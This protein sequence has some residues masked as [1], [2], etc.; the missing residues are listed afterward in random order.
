MYMKYTCAI[1]QM[2]QG[3]TAVPD[4]IT[5]HTINDVIKDLVSEVDDGTLATLVSEQTQGSQAQD[6]TD[7]H[8]EVGYIY[9]NKIY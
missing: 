1:V 5:S 6:T 4:S 8:E 3:G 7:Y 9:N 2:N